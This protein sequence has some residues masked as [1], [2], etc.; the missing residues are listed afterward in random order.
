MTVTQR[1]ANQNTQIMNIKD[2]QYE[3]KIE[4]IKRNTQYRQQVSPN[5]EIDSLTNHLITGLQT[6]Y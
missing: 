1:Q 5:P 4:D 6:K 3:Q 2:S